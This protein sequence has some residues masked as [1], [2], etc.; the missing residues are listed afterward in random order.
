MAGR[1]EARLFT[2]TWNGDNF[3]SLSRHAQGTFFFL[4]SQVD[5]THAGI[6]PLR[7]ARWAK[8]AA[9]LTVG[10]VREDIAVLEDRRYVVTDEEAGELLVRSLVR[11]DKVLRQ[12]FLFPALAE[13]A[14]EAESEAIRAVLLGELLRCRDEG[15]VNAGIAPDLDKLIDWLT[16]SVPVSLLGTLPDT[17]P[18]THA[19]THPN[20][21]PGTHPETHP[22]T[23]AG[24]HS[25]SLQGGGG[26]YNGN[27]KR[28][29]YPQT[30]HPPAPAPGLP[31][32]GEGED[33]RALTAEIRGIR[34]DWSTTSIQRA[35]TA[36]A[37]TERPQDL[38][39]DAALI[40]ARDPASQQPGRLAHDGPWWYKPPAVPATQMPAWCTSCDERTRLVEQAD[41]R[42]ARC[43]D[44][45][46]LTRQ[47]AS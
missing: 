35:L 29:P 22:D 47:E 16:G 45:H 4:L 36:P 42:P 28:S 19:G 34:P 20:R 33:L 30:P 37:V 10:Q 5:L 41:G 13:S 12:P 43:P 8:K 26:R 2:S 14:M 32:S 17:H 7:P 1:S 3:T 15:N 18:D 21:H 40:V 27:H 44:C 6:I 46:P 24:S 11:R 23:H 25:G 38:V 9:G 31:A 39:R